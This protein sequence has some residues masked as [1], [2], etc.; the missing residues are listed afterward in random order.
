M[1]GHSV[2][3]TGKYKKKLLQLASRKVAILV[4]LSALIFAIGQYALILANNESNARRHLRE[5]LESYTNLD[6]IESDFLL[7]TRTMDEARAILN[8]TSNG[9][10]MKELLR[11]LNIRNNVSSQ[12]ILTDRKDEILSTSFRLDSLS[13]YHVNYNAAIC[14]NARD[15][16]D[17]EIYRAIYFDN[18]T[19]SDRMYVKPVFQDDIRL[20]YLTL[21]LSGSEWNYVLSGKNFD[22]VIT[23]LRGNIMYSSKRAFATPNNQF[24]GGK[25]GINELN[26]L[27]Y[28]TKSEQTPDGNACVYAM[29]YYPQNRVA[30]ISVA[31]LILL[32]LAWVITARRAFQTMAQDNAASIEHLVSELRYIRKVDSEHRI[33]VKSDDEFSEVAHQTNYMLDALRE[34]NQRNTELIQL[35]NRSEIDRLTAQIN[36]HFLYNT[37]EIVRSLALFDGAKAEM[38]ITKLT[39]VLRYSI[40]FSQD[41]VALEDDL[42][43]TQNYIDI[44]SLRFGDHFACE[45]AI[46]P[47]CYSCLVPKLLLQPLLE[48]SIKYGFANVMRLS[49]QIEGHMDGPTLQLRV[50]D[51]GGGMDGEKARLLQGQLK[52]HES[53]LQSIGLCNLSRRLY[54]KYGENSGISVMN[55]V[56]KGFEVIVRIENRRDPACTKS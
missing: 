12:Y 41:E 34:L 50:C 18:S 51:N 27:R 55:H 1:T 10:Q 19:Y 44:Q 14:H 9:T 25:S 42:I 23:D 13:S 35:N 29:I 38:V 26:G 6:A 4:L 8:G 43:Y 46:D 37:L 17:G 45:M 20:G 32:I 7:D 22:G 54:L 5:L 33:Q 47:E 16:Q 40:D 31:A 53:S 3:K 36:P 49:L 24:I 11:K 48:N 21:Y 28:W 2:G 56:G 15:H 52:A 30:Y 39:Q